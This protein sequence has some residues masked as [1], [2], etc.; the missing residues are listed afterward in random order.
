MELVLHLMAKKKRRKVVR[1]FG[2]SAE[3]L[4][5]NLVKVER[6]MARQEW[7]A[8]HQKLKELNQRYPKRPEILTALVNL[9]FELEDTKRYQEVAEELLEVDPDNPDAMYGL[10]GAYIGNHHILLG[11]D[12]FRRFLD[13]YP[14][15]DHA[16]Q[17][18]QTLTK[19]ESQLPSILAE[20]GL[21]GE[22]AWELALLHETALNRLE[23][24]RTQEACQLEQQLLERRP[25]F[26][27]A[28]NN[29]SL[30]QWSEGQRDEAIATATKAIE[31][32]PQNVHALSNLTRFFCLNGQLEQA[33]QWS[34]RLKAV[35]TNTTDA[36]LKKAE[37]LSYLGDDAGIVAIL[38]EVRQ[39]GH[40]DTAPP[41]L[42]HLAAAATMRLG[43]EKEARQLWKEA[44]KRSPSFELARANLD[45]LQQPE[46][47][48]HAP[49]AFN[50]SNWID[51]SLVDDLLLFVQ[52]DQKKKASDT[53]QQTVQRYLQ[54][55]PELLHLIPQLLERGDPRGREFALRVALMG[56]TPETLA[57]LKDFAL[58]Q[59][60]PDTM[61][62]EAAQVA[63]EADLI[64]PGE[65]RMW[66]RGQW[67]DILL[68][69]MEIHDEP[70]AEH[71][72]E[73]DE[74]ASEAVMA[75][76]EDE[77]DE[78]ESLLKEALELEPDSPDLLYNLAAAYELQ[79]RIDEARELTKQI[80]QRYPDYGF[81]RLSLARL[82]ISDKEYDEAEAILNPMLQW[83]RFNFQVFA[84][85]CQTQ[86]ELC[87]AKK[88][89][90]SARSWLGMWEQVNPEDPLL[91]YWQQ[92]LKEPGGWLLR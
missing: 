7:S 22:D 46:S 44:L 11:I 12:T 69:G 21:E 39:S 16:E 17:G 77:A 25:N 24:G 58:S 76:R 87:L 28:L 8:A 74:L 85:F 6:H 14:E 2:F 38:A 70:T 29:M 63:R 66:L 55:H 49:W 53:T 52:A 15:H 20:T 60:G 80:Y 79:E 31:A 51:K 4:F 1:G 45:D 34:E 26:P 47:Q 75:L 73:V 9:Y 89:P 82:H 23:Q 71:S 72:L 43:E 86:I 81:A 59:W 88:N 3:A 56:K 37:A 41:L 18:R 92:R 33:Q 78:A 65:V 13:R 10:A 61:R 68:M 62:Q 48:R 42:L 5:A 35:D 64:P 57:A 19:L 91:D 54:Q 50:F 36:W 27:A 83:R 90:D 40:G 67:R 30:A 84:R 32:H